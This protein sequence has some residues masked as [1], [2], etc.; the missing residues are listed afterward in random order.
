MQIQTAQ[1]SLTIGAHKPLPELAGIGHNAPPDPF[2]AFNLH[3]SDLFDQ[4]EQ[5]LDGTGISTQEQ[6]NDVS[7]ILD[8]CR[9][10]RKDADTARADEKRPHDEA[11]KAVQA[12]WKPLLDKCDLAANAAKKAL[13]PWLEA[14]EAEQRAAAEAARVEAEEK[15]AAAREAA[16]NVAPDDLAAQAELARLRDASEAA[17]KAAEKA[18]KA[19][20]QAKGGERAVGLRKR[21]IPTITDRMA[22]LKH[23]MLERP[24]DLAAWLTDQVERDCRVNKR[25]V[26]GVTYK[27]ESYAQ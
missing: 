3:V 23:Y 21:W 26:P 18:G 17:Q 24:D 6:A 20:A 19:K 15:A 9:K 8:M 27:E 22:V 5:F 4:A 2:E 16:S 11:G 1:G 12:K 13:A 25:D 10:A 7:A 14:R